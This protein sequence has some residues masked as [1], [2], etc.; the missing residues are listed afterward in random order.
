MTACPERPELLVGQPIGQ[1]HCP[2]CGCMVIAGLKHGP[3]D[4]GCWLGLDHPPTTT[5]N[6]VATGNHQPQGGA[7]KAQLDQPDPNPPI[8][9]FHAAVE[10]DEIVN[11]MADAALAGVVRAIGDYQWATNKDVIDVIDVL[12]ERIRGLR[13]VLQRSL[14]RPDHNDDV[15]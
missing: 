10:R 12:N 3:H 2:E 9:Q 7:M 14:P 8:N 11:Q 15:F 13:F 4:D 5:D 6:P 1:Y